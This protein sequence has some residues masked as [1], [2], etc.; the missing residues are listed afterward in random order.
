MN[1]FQQSNSSDIRVNSGFPCQSSDWLLVASHADLL[2]RVEER[3]RP[4]LLAPAAQ[5][6]PQRDVQRT[7]RLVAMLSVLSLASLRHVAITDLP[8]RR[9]RSTLW[10]RCS[11]P[12]MAK[13]LL[14][15]RLKSSSVLPRRS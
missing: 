15:H 10:R 14:S 6:R 5:R 8:G 9:R 12:K 2:S 11:K 4:A 1:V 3:L 13:S 7:R